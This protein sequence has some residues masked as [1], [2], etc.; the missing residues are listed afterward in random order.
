MDKGYNEAVEYLK[1]FRDYSFEL[2]RL[3][4][5]IKKLKSEIM[6][7]SS[8]IPNNEHVDT[9]AI[10]DRTKLI[11]NMVDMKRRFEEEKAKYIECKQVARKIIAQLTDSKQKTILTEYYLNDN[12]M[13]YIAEYMLKISVRHT[14]RIRTTALK[15]FQKILKG[16]HNEN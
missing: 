15:S 8:P 4:E 12:T 10:S 16:R 9:S 1:K 7:I 13:E 3:D 6:C 11:D 2:K 5:E 14:Y